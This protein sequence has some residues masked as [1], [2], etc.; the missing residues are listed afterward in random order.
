MVPANTGY[1]AEE[2]PS[3]RAS[4]EFREAEF[5]EVQREVEEVD[6]GLDTD[7]IR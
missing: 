4:R 7:E 3:K 1:T 2:R 6:G 5:R